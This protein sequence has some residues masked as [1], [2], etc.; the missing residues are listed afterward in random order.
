MASLKAIVLR[1]PDPAV[2]GV[3]RWRVV[4]CAGWWR[5]QGRRL[6]RDGDAALVVVA[7]SVASQDP[8]GSPAGQCQGA[9]GLQKGGFA[10]HLNEIAKAHPEATHFE[11]WRQDEARV[12]QKGR[13][14]YLWWQRGHTPRGR[15]DLGRRSAWIIGA[16]CARRDTGLAL[17]MTALDTEAMSLFLA[18]LSQAVVSGAHAIVL[19]DKA[20][21]H[22]AGDL[23]VPA[24]L[25][26]VFLPPYSPELNPIERLWLYLRDPPRLRRYRANHRRQL[27]C[28]E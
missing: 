14:G 1:G 11:I 21:W 19:M 26:L 7:R 18:E 12:G 6:R 22:I 13:T 10:A 25:S 4:D 20:G 16:V 24:N 2:D 5:T 15:R 28:L 8:A 17:V 9:G 3:E 27:R 23:V